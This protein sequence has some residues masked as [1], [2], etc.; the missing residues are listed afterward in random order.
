MVF[1][2]VF[3]GVASD[4]AECENR[5]GRCVPETGGCTDTYGQKTNPISAATCPVSGTGDAQICC[6]KAILGK[7]AGE[8]ETCLNDNNCDVGLRCRCPTGLV[9]TGTTDCANAAG[10]RIARKCQKA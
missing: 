4:L 10:D 9:I 7:K 6:N 1:T 2:G 8:G 3:G 5:G